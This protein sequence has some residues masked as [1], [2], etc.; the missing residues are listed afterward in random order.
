LSPRGITT[1]RFGRSRS[2]Q[3][4]PAAIC[5]YFPSKDDIFFALAEE[6]F[7]L[8]CT[9]EAPCDENTDLLEGIR[10]PFWRVYEFSKSHPEHYALMFVD[11]TVP[12][13]CKDWQ[14]FGFVREEAADWGGIQ[15]SD[16]CD[17]FRRAQLAR[18]FASC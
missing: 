17:I 18:F 13:I 14:R 16:R 7:H 15:P 11:R 5:S 2:L 4:S 3:C 12:K 8:L 6:G 9:R 10:R 1:S